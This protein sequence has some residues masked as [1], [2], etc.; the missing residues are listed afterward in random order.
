MTRDILIDCDPGHDDAVAI[1]LAWA[2]EPEL[3]LL[4]LTTV[5]GNNTLEKVTRNASLILAVCEQSTP[6][7]PGSPRPLIGK[8]I[9]SS[10]F[11]GAS[12]MD[13]PAP[14]SALILPCPSEVSA[15]EAMR[16]ILRRR[17]EPVDIVALA[18]LT[19]LALLIRGYP[20]LIPKIRC[21]SLM[22]GSL[23]HGNITH[24]AEFNIYVDPEAAAIVFSS[25]VPII[26]SGLNVTEEVLL[27]SE[28]FAHLRS[29]GKIGKFFCELMEFYQKGSTVFGA[30]GCMM[31]DPCALL[32]LLRP[33]FFSGVRGSV[34]VILSGPAR[35]KT[36]LIPD[37]S[38]AVLALTGARQD[39]IE[40]AVINAIESLCSAPVP[41]TGSRRHS[42]A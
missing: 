9:I 8:P 6:L 32:Y 24:Q 34:D 21:I 14:D 25:G 17:V 11:H 2:H 13:G 23:A 33:E 18:P 31:H 10:R 39:Q 4:A 27:H 20:D 42:T 12:G 28:N 5:C 1:M 26:M 15:L 30:S 16:D 36:V 38:G 41:M 3:N 19:N 22:G 37:E 40:N 35:G 7:H 29:K